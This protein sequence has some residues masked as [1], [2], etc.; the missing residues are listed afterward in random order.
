M[1]AVVDV[2]RNVGYWC[3][4]FVAAIIGLPK[5]LYQAAEL[6]G[7]GPLSRFWYLTLPLMRRILFFAIVV[8][9]I[10]GFQV[11]DTALVL[12]NG[13]PGTATTTII[14]RV[15][16]YVFAYDDKVGFAAAISLVLIVGVLMLTLIQM[17]LL[18]GERGRTDG[19]RLRPGSQG[20]HWPGGRALRRDPPRPPPAT[21]AIDSAGTSSSSWRP[22]CSSRRS[23]TWSWRR[24][25]TAPRSSP[26]R[27]SSSRSRRTRVTTS[28]FCITPGFLRW[29]FNTLSRRDD[30]YD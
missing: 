14:F 29:M 18:R 15:W 9:T 16:Q 11:F 21:D 6:D 12:T 22:C 25:R 26:T 23:T 1:L 4:F 24:S 3:I 10:W 20:R 30:R 8:S 17:R 2:W 19:R 13:G 27:Q 5:E 28:S 7:A